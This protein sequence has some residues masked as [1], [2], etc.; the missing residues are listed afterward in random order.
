MFYF[1]LKHAMRALQKKR[2]FAA[3][4]IV[5]FAVAIGVNATIFSLR[6]AVLD[7]TIE[8]PNADNVVAVYG[9]SRGNAANGGFARGDYAY[10]KEHLKGVSDLAAHYSTSPMTFS[11]ANMSLQPV[12]GSAVSGNFF[13]MLELRPAV[14]RFFSSEEDAVERQRCSRSIKSRILDS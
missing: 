1:Y 11:A 9:T 3:A 7:R 13:P 10:Y 8:V 6:D 2:T 12:N 4:V 5:T 14:G